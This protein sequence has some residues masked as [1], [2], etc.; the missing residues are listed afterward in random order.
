MPRRVAMWVWLVPAIAGVVSAAWLFDRSRVSLEDAALMRLAEAL[1]AAPARPV[2]GR[3]SLFADYV[4]PPVAMRGE[5]F[6]PSLPSAQVRLAAAE[7]EEMSARSD[8]AR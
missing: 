2:A 4:P 3:L 5:R 1:A 8:T 7:I 6:A